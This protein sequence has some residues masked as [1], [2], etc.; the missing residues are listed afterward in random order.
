[1]RKWIPEVP[2]FGKPITLRMLA[3]H[4][5]GLRDQWALLSLTNRGAGRAVHTLDGI[6]DLV[7]R[8]RDLNFP[9]NDQYLYSNTGFA[10][11]AVVVGRASGKPLSEFTQENIFKPL[12]MTHTQWRDDFTRVVK[13]RA[14]AYN[15]GARGYS[16][17]MPF[18]N[19]YGNGGLLTTVGDLLI[20]WDAL[21]NNRLGS[22]TFLPKMT[23]TGVLN[24][25]QKITYA[26]GLTVDSVRGLRTFSHSG[27]TAGYRANLV[28]YPDKST[29]IGIICNTSNGDPGG[30]IARVGQ[31]L[32]PQ[33]RVA[34]AT[35]VTPAGMTAAELELLAGLYRDPNTDDVIRLTAKDGKLIAA[36]V[37]WVPTSASTLRNA[38]STVDIT[39]R[40]DGPRVTLQYPNENVTTVKLERV[41]TV[42]P[43]MEK[44]KEY[45]GGYW[46]PELELRYDVDIDKGR[47]IIKRRLMSALVL[48][49]TYADAFVGGGNWVFVRDAAGKVTGMV[50]SQGRIRH[51]RFDRLK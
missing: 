35:A 45:V 32:F 1:V 4:T 37:E 49:P 23:T 10:L 43:S 21:S 20:W 28:H 38:R 42:A 24:S 27:S 34:A 16:L 5:S 14:T 13:D 33:Q 36:D 48:N 47:L 12:G 25:G 41:D 19:V 11:L 50:H 3:N 39:V 26:L 29:T 51:V 18:T 2:N 15:G 8:Q 31:L 40:R 6:V 46:S 17:D 30:K 9:P 7:S 22:P 44:L